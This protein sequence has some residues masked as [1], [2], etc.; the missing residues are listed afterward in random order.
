[1]I[2]WFLQKVC[3]LQVWFGGCRMAAHPSPHQPV[4]YIYSSTRIVNSVQSPAIVMCHVTAQCENT[5][6]VAV[7]R[8]GTCDCVKVVFI[9]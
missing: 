3:Y 2:V 8:D 1:M 9:W 5:G 7:E 4:Q 6:C